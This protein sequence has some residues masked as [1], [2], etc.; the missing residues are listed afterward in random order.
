MDHPQIDLIA[1][2]SFLS[3]VTVHA[4]PRLRPCSKIRYHSVRGF[5]FRSERNSQR[6]G[7][8]CRSRLFISTHV[9]RRKE[10]AGTERVQALADISRSALCCHSNETRVPIGNPPNSEQVDGIP[11]HS[12]SFIRVRAVVSECGEGQ[13]DTGTAVT[14]IHFASATPHA[15][16]NNEEK[17]AYTV[18]VSK[19]L[20]NRDR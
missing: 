7:R 20:T 13:T 1:D 12:P 14:D 6:V 5:G 10:K 16:Y 9:Y 3:C 4:I 2:E 19:V 18:F 17:Y 8:I 15:K 11:C